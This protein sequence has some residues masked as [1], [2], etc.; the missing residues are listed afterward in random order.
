MS[1]AFTRWL[2]ESGLTIFGGDDDGSDYG[3]DDADSDDDLED[4]RSDGEPSDDDDDDGSDDDADDD[5][6]DVAKAL[7]DAK[8]ENRRLKRELAAA[9]ELL[10]GVD[11]SDDDDDE[12]GGLR[13]ENQKLRKLVNG[14]YVKSQ[15]DNVRG[16]DGE[17]LYD[18]EDADVVYALLDKSELEVDVETG[19]IEG[20]E[21][22]LAELAKKKPFLLKSGKRSSKGGSK[23]TSRSGRR[24]GTPGTGEKQKSKD[25][26]AAMGLT[27]FNNL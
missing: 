9:E 12:T 5:D 2:I 15:I 25:D 20:L 18:W 21:E 8:K 27:V 3:V 11:E 4:S 7:S 19:E 26:Y 13:D 22:Q 10:D 17:K 1:E 6:D 24:T 23:I 14:P 16:K